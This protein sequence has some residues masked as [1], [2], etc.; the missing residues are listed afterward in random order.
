[1]CFQRNDTAILETV[2]LSGKE[3]SGSEGRLMNPGHAIEAGWFLL[4]H[5]CET[6]NEDLVKTAIDKF[7]M[8]PFETGWGQETWRT[9]LFLGR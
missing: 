2:S 4:E 9:V 6:G 7:I 8:L 5:A 1:M 3:L